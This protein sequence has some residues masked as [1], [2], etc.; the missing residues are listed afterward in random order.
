[1]QYPREANK[2]QLQGNEKQIEHA[3]TIIH[4]IQKKQQAIIF[5]QTN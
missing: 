2:I 1:M 3:Q 5:V 4:V